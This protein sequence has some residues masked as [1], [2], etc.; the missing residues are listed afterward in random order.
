[1]SIDEAYTNV[2][3]EVYLAATKIKE[4]RSQQQAEEQKR[5][6][7]AEQLRQQQAAEA[8]RLKQQELERQYQARLT[9]AAETNHQDKP[10]NQPKSSP[11]T[12]RGDYAQLESL[13]KAGKWKEADE[14]TTKKMYEVMG[15]RYYLRDQDMQQFPCADLCT[16]DQLWVKYSHGRFGFSVQKKIWQRCGSPKKYNSQ[17][18]KFGVELGWRTKGAAILGGTWKCDEE[19]TL[20]MSAP[21]GH[22]PA[23]F[24]VLTGK[25]TGAWRGR[26]GRAW[27]FS[28]LVQRLAE[29]RI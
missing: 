22:F 4:R 24:R 3:E 18:E 26:G 2:L 11:D 20:D 14:A 29:C 8:K 28:S 5:L 1:M 9:Q 17:W 7:Q 25:E 19:L 23:T 13:L 27:G 15:Q 12:L 6:H 10:D 21:V 16:I